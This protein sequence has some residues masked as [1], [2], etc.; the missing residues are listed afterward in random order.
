MG[1]TDF[2]DDEENPVL[3]MEKAFKKMDKFMVEE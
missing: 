1:K 2:P 3:E